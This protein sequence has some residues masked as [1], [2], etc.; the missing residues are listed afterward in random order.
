MGA[1]V[2][3]ESYMPRY[4]ATGDLNMDSNGRWSPYYEEK[5]SNNQLCNGF[6]TKL[7]DG[8]SDFDKEMLRH[9]MLEHDAIFRQQVSAH[10][11]N[12]HLNSHRKKNL[13]TTHSLSRCMN[14]TEFT[15]YREI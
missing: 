13:L 6:M 1:Q 14:Y 9:T 10:K 5:T 11:I 4:Y 8:Y 2:E 15:N 12:K 7:T 3:G